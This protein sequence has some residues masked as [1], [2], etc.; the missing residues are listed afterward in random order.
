MKKIFTSLLL[1]LVST[2][3]LAQWSP[4]TMKG[5]RVRA[6]SKVM[7]YYT[8]NLGE[9]RSLLVKAKE[10]GKGTAPVII[11]LPTLNG[12]IEKFAVYS[13]PVV[14]KSLA[15]R[16]ELGSFTGQGVDDPNAFVRFSISPTEFQAMMLKN[17]QYEFIEAQ[18]EPKTIYGVHPK[19]NKSEADKAFVC[20]TT[21]TPLKKG[22]LDKLY[23]AGKSFTNNPADFSKSNDRK[24]RTMRLALS[25]NGEYTQYF[26]GTVAGALTAINNTLTRV[27]FIFEKD[28][29]LHLILQD[30]PQLIYTDPATDPYTS[31]KI[32]DWNLQLQQTLTNTIGS[33]AYDIGHMFGASGGGGNAGCIGCVCV[34]PASSSDLGKG[35]GITSPADGIPKGD[36]FDVDFVAHELGHQLG[37]NHTFSYVVEGTG[38]NM[39]PGSGSTIMG[40]AGITGATDVQARGDA[41]FHYYSIYQVQNNLMA[42]TCDVETAIANNPPVINAMADLTIPKET[43]FYLTASATDAEGD[44]MTF[45]WEEVDDATIATNIGNL[46]TLP[47]GPTF[48]SWAPTP[49]PTRFFPKLSKVLNGSLKSNADW[50]A[51]STVGR[52]QNFRVT[53][54]DN[55]PNPMQQQTQ[56]A[57][58]KL[59]ISNNGPFKVTSTQVFNNAVA[60]LTWDTAGTN[61]A[62]FNVTNVKIDYTVN[63]GANWTV[64]SA[65]TP[66]D[67]TEDFSFPSLA[68]NTSIKIRVSAINSVFYA[69]APATVTQ[70]LSCDGTAPLNLTVGSITTSSATLSWDPRIDA[71]YVVRYKK[72]TSAVWTELT[73]NS[74]SIILSGLEEGAAYTVQVA[75]I[76]SGK[77]GAFTTDLNFS[78]AMFEYCTLVAGSPEDEYILSVQVTAENRPT[79]TSL[80]GPSSYTNYM[81]DPAR[82]INLVRGTTNN[83]ITVTKAWTAEQYDDAIT[84]WIDF[85]RSGTFD[86]D[87]MILSTV[88]N[89]TTPVSAKFTVPADAFVGDK[90]LGMRVAL[91]YDVMQDNPCGTFDYGEVE[92]YAVKI[93]A[94]AE[95]KENVKPTSLQVY[96][97]PTSEYLN[98]IEVAADSPYAIYNMAGQ[99]V[100]KGN[101]NN[102]QVDVSPLSPG[103]Y[104]ISVNNSGESGQVKFIKK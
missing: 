84:A 64:L 22:E 3:L 52:V 46:G 79:M 66:N 15:D 68:I 100:L 37:A 23:K 90:L 69:I 104:I 97:N 18:N 43:A 61:A 9:M 34:N 27:N 39:E 86:N 81:T 38:A 77:R 1:S 60:A 14:V 94:T 54:R 6:S 8:L 63:N 28:F 44:P 55:N 83:T 56:S 20:S 42:K 85:D 29:A 40:Y 76:C 70:I 80:S 30:F 16:Y 92:D 4:T 96:P 47:T 91:R 26:G 10:T 17:G 87:E 24:Y 95:V 93:S 33:S 78:A 31:S 62:P 74:N 75:T 57:L 59:T 103:V 41:Y 7:N 49:N 65:S 53:V 98:F 51:V 19:T 67:G 45:T 13:S 82:V 102:D 50:E 32:D 48:R 88:P 12:K 2:V 72:S 89:T 73:V 36:N 58:Q 5:E 35:S 11:K 71:T 99:V 21:E 25:V 101:L